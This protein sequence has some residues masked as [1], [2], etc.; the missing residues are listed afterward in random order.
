MTPPRSAGRYPRLVTVIACAALLLAGCGGS[1]ASSKASP[2]A[3][4]K[5]VCGAVGDWVAAVKA[6]ES[7]LVEQLPG[8]PTP[9]QG[10]RLLQSFIAEAV[11]ATAQARSKISAAGVPDVNE[12]QHVASKVRGAFDQ[13]SSVLTRARADTE[14]LPTSNPTAFSIAATQLGTSVQ[15]A[16]SSI[17]AGLSAL[18]S[19]QLEAAGSTI[20]ACQ[21]LKTL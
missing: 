1:S 14:H 11:S 20:P 10:R 13:I 21:A 4:L 12:G 5:S 9:I 16:L 17:G 8:S 7:R 3:Y 19:P 15:Q 18:R 6:R 2:S